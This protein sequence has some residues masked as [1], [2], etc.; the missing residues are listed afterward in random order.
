MCHSNGCSAR[1]T[2]ASLGIFD[3]AWGGSSMAATS[4]FC[5]RINI[6]GVDH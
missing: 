2:A 3:V 5:V 4:G 1:A 6:C